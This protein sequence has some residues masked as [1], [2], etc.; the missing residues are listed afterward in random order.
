MT[1]LTIPA[2]IALLLCAACAPV[3]AGPQAVRLD[4]VSAAAYQAGRTQQAAQTQDAGT[5]TSAARADAWTVTAVSRTEIAAVIAATLQ[6]GADQATARA[7]TPTMTPIPTGTPAPTQTPAP[8]WT[9]TPD[10]TVAALVVDRARAERDTAERS[11][12]L[13]SGVLA[14]ALLGGLALVLYGAGRLWASWEYHM[15][16]AA[17][18][19]HISAGPYYDTAS[20][21]IVG[22]LPA[23]AAPAASDVEPPATDAQTAEAARQWGWRTAVLQIAMY[24]T[25]A[26][27]WAYTALGP[28][29]WGVVTR[30]GWD[31][32]TEYL[33][34]CGAIVK[35]PQAPTRWADGVD[36]AALAELVR[37][38]GLPRAYPPGPAPVLSAPRTHSAQGAQPA[39]AAQKG[40]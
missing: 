13:L 31:A 16:R 2:M 21:Q 3:S 33:S 28:A 30:P 5:A 24:A 6:A 40:F 32:L 9:M 23:P 26:D 10:A 11:G 7:L 29:G 38:R 35:R 25:E 4:D 27:S 34:E 1:D 8:T 39:Q 20:G 19:R 36:A 17:R 37:G 18:E 22:L 15:A 14:V 12:W